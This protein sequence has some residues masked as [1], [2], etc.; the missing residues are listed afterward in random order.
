MPVTG[1]TCPNSGETTVWVFS[2]ERMSQA[3]VWTGAQREEPL[4]L[5]GSV[6]LVWSLTAS[7]CKMGI[8]VL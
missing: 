4:L 7:I 6:D 8:R 1:M 3:V 2:D 5:A